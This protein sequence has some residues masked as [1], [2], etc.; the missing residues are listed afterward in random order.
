[1]AT[2]N[3]FSTRQA[4][5]YFY[6]VVLNAQDEPT[7]YHR[8]HNL[9]DH[10]IKRHP[11]FVATMLVSGTNNATLVSF[12]EQKSQTVFCW[13]DWI[14]ACNL[15]FTFCEDGT[16]TKYTT[17]A[18]ISTE[19]LPKY[20]TLVVREVEIDIGLAIPVKN[21]HIK[22]L[23]GILPYFNRDVTDIIYWLQ[24][25]APSTGRWP[26]CWRCLS[27]DVHLYRLNLAAQLF[28]A[29][30]VSLLNKLQSLM[31]KLRNLNQA[32]KL[33]KFTDLRPVLSQEM[34]WDST[35]KMVKRSFAIKDV[36]DTTDDDVA[37]LMPTRH[38]K[39]KLL[40]LQ[41]DLRDFKSAPKKLQSDKAVTL[42]DVRDILDALIDR[43]PVVAKYL[44]T[45][46]SI[47]KSPVFEDA[48]TKVLLGKGAEHSQNQHEL[49]K[50]F[51]VHV[52]TQ[53]SV[54]SYDVDDRAGF[55]SAYSMRV[56]SS[57]SRL[58]CMVG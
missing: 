18:R 50:P 36:I 17:L 45:D 10:V 25:T 40:S 8:C 24:T 35:Y 43:H 9:I 39:N 57:V 32:A 46:A 37:E 16:M 20:A 12:I 49:L 3:P 41:E 6:K 26:I 51:A 5:G 58:T 48:C 7:P 28:M 11:D 56:R 31:R 29:D 44:S 13:I 2:N 21:R 19:T 30:H 53:T 23:K 42:L 38:E 34:R 14:T 54:D 15:P 55:P 47:V 33:R 22:F 4:C 1:M 27:S 52:G